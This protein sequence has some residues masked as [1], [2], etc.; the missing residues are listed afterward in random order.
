MSYPPTYIQIQLWM[1]T[2][3]YWK[4]LFVQEYHSI[5]RKVFTSPYKST[6]DVRRVLSTDAKR[7]EFIVASRLNRWSLKLMVHNTF[8]EQPGMW[9]H[10]ESYKMY[11]VKKI[12]LVTQTVCCFSPFSLFFNHTW[13][14]YLILLQPFIF[15]NVL[16]WVLIP[17]IYHVYL[18]NTFQHSLLYISCTMK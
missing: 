16:A 2:I 9:T 17:C 8:I 1:F 11:R 7:G 12:P 4:A 13:N 6:T 3:V 10:H 18:L 14:L 15:K 5:H